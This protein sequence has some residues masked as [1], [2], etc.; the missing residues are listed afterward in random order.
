MQVYNAV[1]SSLSFWNDSLTIV[2]YDEHGGFFDHVSPP[3]IQTNPPTGITYDSFAS[4]GPRTPAY[5]LSPFVKPGRCVRDIFDHTSVLKFIGEKFANS[6]Y[7]PEVDARP[8]SSLSAALTF[9]SPI[10]TP[11]PA[12]DTSDYLSRQPKSNPYTVRIPPPDNDLQKAF[13]VGITEMK[14]QGGSNH[15]VFGSLLQ[16]VP[17]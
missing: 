3:L 6:S 17:D 9:D 5:I 2:S 12:P 11:P 16:Q 8:V 4:L 7:S 13:R 1:T 15:P 10:S 14:R